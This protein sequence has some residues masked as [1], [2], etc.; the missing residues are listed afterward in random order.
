MPKRLVSILAKSG[1]LF[2]RLVQ[3]QLI[4]LCVSQAVLT[5]SVSVLEWRLLFIS[6]F[7][8]RCTTIFS[9]CLKL[10]GS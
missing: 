9:L 1:F 3:D 4:L 10:S 6:A 8:A 7:L 5:P 2:S